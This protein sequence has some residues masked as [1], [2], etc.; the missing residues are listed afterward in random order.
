MGNSTRTTN[1]FASLSCTIALIVAGFLFYSGLTTEPA[2]GK[3]WE[4]GFGAIDQDVVLGIHVDNVIVN[5]LLANLPQLIFSI[6]YLLYNAIVTAQLVGQEWGSFS[7]PSPRFSLLRRWRQRQRQPPRRIPL[8]VTVARGWQ[9][10]TYYLGIPYTYGLPLTLFST[11]IHWLISRSLFLVNMKF[12]EPTHRHVTQ[13][14]LSRCGYSLPPIFV[15]ILLSVL[16]LLAIIM[17]GLRRYPKGIP[18]AGTCS[19]AISAACHVPQDERKECPDLAYRPLRWGVTIE[20][21]ELY[22]PDATDQPMG[23]DG[24]QDLVGVGHCSFTHRDDVRLPTA[25]EGW[26][27]GEVRHD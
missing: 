21:G 25:D 1:E 12:Y 22:Y 5:T 6:L 8:R 2:R 24:A 11:L 19:L 18:L 3:W 4:Q 16:L 27:M 23:V 7:L 9:T 17:S 14:H 13:R 20:P 10:S 15:S 26:Y